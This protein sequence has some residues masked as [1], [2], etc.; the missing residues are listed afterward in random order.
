[1]KIKQLLW[2]KHVLLRA[3]QKRSALH[4]SPIGS[5]DEYGILMGLMPVCRC[6]LVGCPFG[7]FGGHDPNA[8]AKT[9]G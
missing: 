7:C 5:M 8:V 1:M 6:W 9:S 3:T 4:R 2:A